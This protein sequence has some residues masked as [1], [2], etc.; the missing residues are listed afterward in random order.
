MAVKKKE[1]IKSKTKGRT[2]RPPGTKNRSVKQQINDHTPKIAKRKKEQQQQIRDKFKG[3]EYARQLENCYD[4]YVNLANELSIAAIKRANSQSELK[5]PAAKTKA[6][7]AKQD[8]VKE[9]ARNDIMLLNAQVDLLRIRID[10]IKGKIDLN[11]RRLKFCLPELK[12]M[13]LSDPSGKNPLDIFAA[14]VAA[15]GQS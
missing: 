9:K 15:M 1:P 2:G 5:K 14:A 10:V 6:A 7:K 4:E 3:I 13:E 12:A 11:L 8:I